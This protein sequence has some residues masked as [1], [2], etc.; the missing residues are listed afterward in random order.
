MSNPSF[1]NPLSSNSLSSNCLYRRACHS[2][3]ENLTSDRLDRHNP[4]SSLMRWSRAS[5]VT[6]SKTGDSRSNPFKINGNEYSRSDRVGDDE[7]DDYYRFDLK[8]KREIKISVQNKEFF[9]G[10]ALD[11]RLLDKNGNKIKSKH[12]YGDDT[13]D[14]K[15]DL[16]KGTYYIKVESGGNSVPYK[17]KFKSQS[18]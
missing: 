12:V 9:L 15:R 3:S 11:F 7:G 18:P 4:A 6:T 1:S 17:L 2:L 5:V 13:E 14:I 8:N 10:P 16:N